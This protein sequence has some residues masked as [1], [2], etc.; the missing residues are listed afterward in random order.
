MATV[1]V[2]THS[3]TVMCGG[4]KLQGLQTST[5]ARQT[6]PA[7]VTEQAKFLQYLDAKPEATLVDSQQKL[8]STGSGDTILPRTGTDQTMLPSTD[9]DV[10]KVQSSNVGNMINIEKYAT[11][12]SRLAFKIMQKIANSSAAADDK[13]PNKEFLE[14]L[15]RKDIE[16]E[17]RNEELV[18][19]CLK[20]PECGIMQ[21]LDKIDSLPDSQNYIDNLKSLLEGMD[22]EI[23]QDMLMTNLY[24][25]NV[26]HN[27]IAIVHE[28][29]KTNSLRIL[30]LC[31]P[32]SSDLPDRLMV[33]LE[34]EPLINANVTGTA[35][36]QD[37]MYA[38]FLSNQPLLAEDTEPY[39]LILVDELVSES[40]NL[41]AVLSQLAA[42]ITDDGFVLLK[43]MTHNLNISHLLQRFFRD[44]KGMEDSEFRDFGSFM[45]QDSWE[46]MF[47]ND[48]QFTLVSSFSDYL[49]SSIFLLRKVPSNLKPDEQTIVHFDCKKEFS[50]LPVLQAQL[51]L[52][53]KKPKGQG[54]WLVVNGEPSSGIVGMVKCLV[55][56]PSGKKL[57]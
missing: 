45:E 8:P 38:N 5:T 32:K 14:E 31:R 12:C 41:T 21:C 30:T 55:K 24:E 15:S 53:V 10:V 27:C 26:L 42:S 47:S 6:G 54:L 20:S 16:E 1:T 23:R 33:S 18:E 50:W 3:E 37:T 28:N 43:E 46:K 19:K 9:D 51:E 13:L 2:D 36:D 11:E 56:E 44:C 35:N 25:G 4:V 48:A 57:R 49:M 29:C 52:C 7:V 22:S 40:Q 17:S 39:H 34:H